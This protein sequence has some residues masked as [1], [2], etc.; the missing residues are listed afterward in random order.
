MSKD[1]LDAIREKIDTIDWEIVQLLNQRIEISVRARK[2][3]KQIFDPIRERQIFENAKKHAGKLMSPQTAENIYREILKESKHSQEKGFILIGFQGEHGAY[4]ESAALSYG[5]SLIPLPCREFYQVFHEVEN[6]QLDLG[7]VPIE[8]SLEG[9]VTQAN[10]LLI[11]KDLKIV[12]EIK[13]PIHHCLLAPRGAE[14][15]NLRVVYSHPQALAQC[16]EFVL[17]HK[18]EPRPYYDTAGAAK[19]L[20]D[21]KPDASCVLANK[22]CAE[23]YGLEV[24]HEDVEDHAS[25]TTRFVILS[26]RESVETGDKCTI[27]FSLTDKA[28]ALFSVLKVFFDRS[29]NLTRIE[30]RPLRSSPGE[31]IFFADFEGSDRDKNVI[32]ALKKVRDSVK[33]YKF[34]GCYR[35][36]DSLSIE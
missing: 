27:T 21:V 11:E 34:H 24:I 14:Y 36:N 20:S 6:G 31:Y 13:M 7:I 25:N 3:K 10:D 4:S 30:S 17:R 22:L 9:P 35:S 8:N 33:N 26:K 19:M 12:G 23:L 5:P 16:R 29:L 1:D 28:G 32:A 18:L 15:R 2:L